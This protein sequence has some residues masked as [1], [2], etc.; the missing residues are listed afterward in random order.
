M[1]GGKQAASSGGPTLTLL[2]AEAEGELE[3]FWELQTAASEIPR[4]SPQ[5]NIWREAGSQPGSR[6][7]RQHHP[8]AQLAG[9]TVS[10]HRQDGQSEHLPSGPGDGPCV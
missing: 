10:P 6:D 2:L 3:V 8:P 9:P 7:C 4:T 1:L 5:R